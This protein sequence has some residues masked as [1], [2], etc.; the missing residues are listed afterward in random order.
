M[1][2]LEKEFYLSN[3]V[4][5]IAKDLLGK[6]LFVSNNNRFLSGIIVETEAY[7]AIND[8]ANHAYN[9]K[10]T[11]RT[12]T[13]FMEGGTVYVYLCYGIH[14]LFNVVTNKIDIPEVEEHI[15]EIRAELAPEQPLFISAIARIGV[16]ELIKKTFELLYITTKSL[17][18]RDTAEFKVFYPQPVEE[19]FKVARTGETFSVIGRKVERLVAMTDMSTRESRLHLKKQLKR[20][21]VVNALEKEGIKIGD[22]VRFGHKEME[23]E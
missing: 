3:D 13:M 21:G 16:P 10:K 2:K 1:K 5:Q 11:K 22:L 8:K 7:S 20:L 4:A 9:N 6:E 12:E 18:E 23:W 14:Y 15:P 19:R 17:A